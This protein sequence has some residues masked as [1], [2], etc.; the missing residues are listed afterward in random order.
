MF[1]S[2]E[3]AMV[4]VIVVTVSI[5]FNI[6]QYQRS[7]SLQQALQRLQ[8]EKSQ[9]ANT[10]NTINNNQSSSS[11]TRQ[12]ARQQFIASDNDDNT[13]SQSIAAVA[14]KAV[15]V[16]NGFFQ[17][18]RYEGTVMDIKVD[19]R[20]D[21]NGLILVNTEIPTGVDFQSSAK[22]AVKVAQSLTGTDLST[23][24]I[25]FSI[26]AAEG[27]A[28]EDLQAV[29]G[30]SAGAAMTV[31][32]VSQLQGEGQQRQ[33]NQDVLITGTINPDGTIGPVGA[34]PQKADA[35]GQYGAEL[36]LV[37]QGQ[38]F[39]LAE[40]C[41][42]RRDGPIIYRTCRSEEKPLSELTEQNYG[43]K[44]VEVSSVRDALE[45]FI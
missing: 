27:S 6:I 7:E 41:Q 21:G 24:D 38:A 19:I 31:L 30:G 25:I 5:G 8:A 2:K 13:T 26:T 34:V 23:K 40:S 16:T 32:L 15:P 1:G 43:M 14:V 37:P 12:N 4:L 10:V 9:T 22:T 35:A 20:N 28:K 36:F 11:S 17:S 29:D 42:E 44:V 45:Y 33:L 18:V 39:Y 3:I